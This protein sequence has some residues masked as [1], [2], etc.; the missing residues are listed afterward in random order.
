M[1]YW[2]LKIF[3]LGPLIRVF[4]DPWEE[5]VENVP[6]HGGAILAS[7]HL[8]FSDSIFLP[9]ALPRRVTFPAKMEYFVERGVKG[10]FWRLFFTSTGQIPIDRSGGNASQAAVQAGLDVLDR[11]ELFGIYPEGTRSPDGRLYRGK[12]GMAR[13]ALTARVPIIPVA[14]IDTDK[15]QPTGQ[16]V[17]NLVRI[18]IRYG[19]PMDLSEY[20][21]RE[22]DHEVLRDITD[23]VMRE[24]SRLSGREYVDEYAADRKKALDR[25]KERAA[26]LKDAGLEKADALR[27]EGMQRAETFRQ[28]RLQRAESLTADGLAKTDRFLASAL[29]KA[30]RT[31]EDAASDG[32]A[33]DADGGTRTDGDVLTG[34]ASAEDGEV[35][36]A[37][38][39]ADRAGQTA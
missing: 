12:T 38:A 16:K 19:E 6:A 10:W 14:M 34:V 31:P 17:P 37:V 30:G 23:Q 32:S 4:I 24:L 20:Y 3:I 9:V 27:A 39:D 8:S 29:A 21:G 22:N 1:M 11:G 36:E 5:G 26:E 15:A 35:P 28:E 2:I 18:G 33:I 13:M 25:L 7:N